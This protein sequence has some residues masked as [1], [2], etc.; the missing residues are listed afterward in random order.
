MTA[1]GAFILINVFLAFFNLLP[2]P[3]FDGSHI[4]GGLLPRRWAHHW[5]KL[6]AMGMILFVVLIAATWAFPNAGFIENTVLPPVLWMQEQFF[7]IASGIGAMVA[8]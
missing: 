3:P 5:Q 1:G 2:I 6:Q 7:A 4:V 8:G